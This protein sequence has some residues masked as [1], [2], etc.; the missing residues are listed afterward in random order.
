MNQPQRVKGARSQKMT[1]PMKQPLW[2]KRPSKITGE[3]VFLSAYM[4]QKG[5]ATNLKEI[6]G[7][8]HTCL[9][10]HSEP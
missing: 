4:K 2:A 10:W 3:H 6:W 7:S 9:T 5:N 8:S 1:Q